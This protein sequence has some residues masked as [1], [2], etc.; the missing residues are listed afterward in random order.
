MP[1]RLHYL[2]VEHE[3][4]DV[5]VGLF[6]IRRRVQPMHEYN[7]LR[8]DR[9]CMFAELQ[10]GVRT[11]YRR[12]LLKRRRMRRVPDEHRWVRRL[13][14]M[15]RQYNQ[16]HQLVHAVR[17]RMHTEW[18]CVRGDHWQLPCVECLSPMQNVPCLLPNLFASQC[19]H[20]VLVGGDADQQRHLP[21]LH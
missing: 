15:Q 19:V 5:R 3:L 8:C 12:I 10:C 21:A 18:R 17:R 6:L 16:R 9:V 13:F 14:A 7:E 20:V 11:V 4:S 2:H 1:Y